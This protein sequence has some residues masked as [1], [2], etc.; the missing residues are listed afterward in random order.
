[1]LKANGIGKMVA[2][3]FLSGRKRNKLVVDEIMPPDLVYS[4]FADFQN[5]EQ[6]LFQMIGIEWFYHVNVCF[7]LK[8]FLNIRH[9]AGAAVND[10]RNV[11]QAGIIFNLL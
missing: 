9:L 4:H 11:S 8:A 10:H 7:V 3:W 2:N 5:G 6:G 1:M